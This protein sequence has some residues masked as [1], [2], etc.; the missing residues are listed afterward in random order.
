MGETSTEPL[1]AHPQASDPIVARP[2]RRL[3]RRLARAIEDLRYGIATALVLG[4]ISVCVRV[5]GP[6]DQEDV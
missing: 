6:L 5:F 2:Y 1:E 4:M 3:T